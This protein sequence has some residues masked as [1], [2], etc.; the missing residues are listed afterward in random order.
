MILSAIYTLFLYK[1]L[2]QLCSPQKFL[3]CLP[4]SSKFLKHFN[5][6]IELWDPVHIMRSYKHCWFL[7]DTRAEWATTKEKQ[8]QCKISLRFLTFLPY[9]EV[10]SDISNPTLFF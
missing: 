2:P 7:N 8:N 5:C 1:E 6:I 4:P 9:L 10:S 3:K